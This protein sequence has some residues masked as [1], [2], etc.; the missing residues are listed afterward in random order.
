MYEVEAEPVG[1]S[2]K[3]QR[4]Q[5]SN[6]QAKGRQRMTELVNRQGA[7]NAEKTHCPQNHEY[8]EANTVKSK[9]RRF[10]KACRRV[11]MLR[12]LASPHAHA[13]AVARWEKYQAVAN[14]S[15]A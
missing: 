10:C 9:G 11:R 12:Y 13:R 4:G 6:R 14:G 2:E 7:Y 3:D 8:S 1:P 5:L 15:K